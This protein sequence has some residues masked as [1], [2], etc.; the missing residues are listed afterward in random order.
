MKYFSGG[1]LIVAVLLTVL[2]SPANATPQVQ[3]RG[4][5]LGLGIVGGLEHFRRGLSGFG[6][7]AGFNARLGYR[8]TDYLAAEG[9]Y[10]YMDKFGLSQTLA[11]GARAHASLTTHSFSLLGKVNLPTV[12]NI[13]PFVSPGIGFLA[14]DSSVRVD[15]GQRRFKVGDDSIAFA[16]RVNGGLDFL[17]TEKLG[18]TLEAGY[19]MPSGNLSDLNYISFGLGAR[20]HF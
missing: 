17:L 7:S 15:R 9:L 12:G 6:D 2:I 10:E 19:V 8:F 18:L 13:Q 14:A 3:Q 4:T 5:Y 16:G 11:S 20:Y 1:V